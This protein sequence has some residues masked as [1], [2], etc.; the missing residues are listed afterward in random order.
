VRICVLRT[1]DRCATHTTRV[2]VLHLQL[3]DDSTTVMDAKVHVAAHE[4]AC[5]RS[6]CPRQTQQ[7]C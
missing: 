5:V 4:G 6:I 7:Q 3:I 2:L 1:R